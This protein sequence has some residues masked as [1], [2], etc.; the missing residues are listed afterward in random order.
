MNGRRRRLAGIAAAIAVLHL[1]GMT[2]KAQT[3]YP[4]RPVKIVVPIAPGG[5]YDLVGV[6]DMPDEKL[7][8]FVA[9][10]YESWT[11]L[12]RSAGIKLD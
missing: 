3:G 1:A 7:A 2:A 5:S 11:K 8:P 9:S 4:D 10:E 6:W 12:I